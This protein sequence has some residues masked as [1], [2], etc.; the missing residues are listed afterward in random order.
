[1]SKTK[2]EIKGPIIA[3]G[4]QWIY[5]WF[6]I[7][8]T[9][10]KKVND[11]LNKANGKDV[12]IIINSG[13]GSVFSGSEIYTSLKDYKGKTIGKIVGIA[14]SAASV[15][16]MGTNEL[17]ISPT[18]QIMIHR[19]S[20]YADGNKN[21][22]Q[23][24]VDMLEGAD[25]SIAN[26]YLLKTGISQNELLDMMDKETWLT[27]QEAKE[28]GFAD[29]IMFEDEIKAVASV[30]G[31]GLLPRSVIDKVRNELKNQS[32]PINNDKN[33][34]KIKAEKLELAKAKLKLALI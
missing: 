16:A 22:L 20:I 23:K 5:D 27:A 1:M 12:E 3:D 9:S 15:I 6:G 26:A 18:A 30:D 34:E 4:D 2:I 7:P 32:E 28:K 21:E 11:V 25:K 31:S 19:A 17:L 10:P 8:A 14:A 33:K 13:G 24:T 29:K